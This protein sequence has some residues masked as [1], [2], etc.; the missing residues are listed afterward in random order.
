MDTQ[1]QGQVLDFILGRRLEPGSSTQQ[2]SLPLGS[3][4]Q[5]ERDALLT[6]A[7]GAEHA[8][9]LT[10]GEQQSLPSDK[11]G[12]PPC[13]TDEATGEVR[14]IKVF[15]AKATEGTRIP[16]RK[17]GKERKK[18]GRVGRQQ[19]AVLDLKGGRKPGLVHEEIKADT[20][21]LLPGDRQAVIEALSALLLRTSCADGDVFIQ[22]VQ[23]C[24][25]RPSVATE[26]LECG[27]GSWRN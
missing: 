3:S 15:N 4:Q 20:A 23:Y 11:Q 22:T 13:C 17:E 19:P 18:D 25:H 14:A 8:Q 9:N 26:H 16:D 7:V 2:P 6:A 21:E 1:C 5:L 12:Q 10:T 27:S 24:S